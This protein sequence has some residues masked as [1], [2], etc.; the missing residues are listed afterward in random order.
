LIVLAGGTDMAEREGRVALVTGASR[1]IGFEIARG[2]AE[3]GLTVLI[4]TRNA[5]AAAAAAATLSEQGLDVR[6]LQLDVAD[7]ASIGRAVEAIERDFGRL[8]ILVNNAGISLGKGAVPSTTDLDDMR[9]VYETNVFGVVAMIQAML[10]LL[11][12]S[13]AGRIVNMSTGLASLALTRGPGAPMAFSRLLAYNSSKTALNAVTVQF[14]N[15]LADTPIKI[16]AAN[17]GLCATE[18]TG[19]QG[20]PPSEG[21]AV[22]IGLALLDADGPTGGHFG[23]AGPVPW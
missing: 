1:G 16:N 3:R 12:R 7:P 19:G 10:P 4:G 17:P 5:E 20:R 8:D 9:R 2:L 6:G 13:E 18:L 21:A 22:A 23:D 11:L 14:A 15:E